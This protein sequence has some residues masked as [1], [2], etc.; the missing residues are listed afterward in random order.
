MPESRIP[1]LVRHTAFVVGVAVVGVAVLALTGC[2]GSPRAASP[3]AA[4]G[5]TSTTS[6][7]ATSTSNP[8]AG[9]VATT[10]PA[11]AAGGTPRP[12]HV[13]VVVLENHTAGSIIGSSQAPFLNGLVAGGALFTQSYAI[14]HPSEPNYLALF[15]GSTQGITDDSCPHTFAAPNLATSL[16]AVGAT[17]TGYSED[18]PGV[19]S[20]E[21]SAGS[22]ARKHNPWVNF[23]AIPAVANQPFSAF[24]ADPARLPT[25]SF[26]IPNLDHDMH[27]GTIGQADSWL[28]SNLGEYAGWAASHNSLLVITFDED[29]GSADNRIATI[30][31]GAHVRPGSYPERIDHYRLLRTLT[32]LY[33]AIPPGAAAARTPITSIWE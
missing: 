32:Q 8:V 33:G 13:V 16:L 15:S 28:H 11:P 10:A 1:L 20:T 24:P 6:S 23:P 4:P 18:L 19:G 27:D 7:Q 29:D 3:T 21:C 9:T 26:V 22:Y 14:T 5:T 25:V 12:D 2:G 30:V 17:F 31:N